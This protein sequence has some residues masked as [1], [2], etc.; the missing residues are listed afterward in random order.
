MIRISKEYKLLIL[1]MVAGLA[2]ASLGIGGGVIIVPSL[3]LF[4]RYDIK[5]AIGIS[6]ATIVPAAFVGVLAHYFINKTVIDFIMVASIAAGSIIGAKIG[7]YLVSKVHSKILKILF[8]I[9]LL[10]VGFKL[11]GILNIPTESVMDVRAYPLLTVLGLVAGITSAFFGIG[12]GVV[13]V[14]VL[15]LFFGLPIHKAIPTSLAV[16]F[17]TA[18]AGVLFHKAFNNIEL[19]AIKFMVPASLVGAVL[20]AIIA[21][22][23]P[24]EALKFMFGILMILS[25][26][27]LFLPIQK[28]LTK[29]ERVI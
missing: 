28:A 20:G 10:I 5:K 11:T 22:V 26:V 12:G 18:F 29:E 15:N 21:N 23:M 8:A 2:S 4:F 9:F 25:A 24:A 7:A 13:I 6:L 14:P 16:I 3:V 1:G 17:P 27:K 19:S